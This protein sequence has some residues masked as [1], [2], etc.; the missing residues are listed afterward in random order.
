MRQNIFLCL[1][2]IT[3]Q[4]SRPLSFV[5]TK[6]FILHLAESLKAIL[7]WIK[8]HFFPETELPMLKNC[9]EEPSTIQVLEKDYYLYPVDAFS[10]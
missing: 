7:N 4:A 3:N 1:K 2:L 9:K 8:I 10:Y 6:T 5:Q